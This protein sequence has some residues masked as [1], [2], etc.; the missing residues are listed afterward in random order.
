MKKLLSLI[1]CLALGISLA[2][3]GSS[4]IK[5][6]IENNT[7]NENGEKQY[8]IGICQLVQ[9]AALDAAT[10]GFEDKVIDELGDDVIILNQNASG[11][12]ANCST[13]INSFV[14]KNVDLILANATSPLQAAASATKK[15]PILGTSITDYGSAL[16]LSNFNGI[17]GGNV[18]GTSDLAPLRE[19]AEMIKEWCP[20][21]KTCGI[22]FCSSEANSEY[23]VKEMT[24][25]LKELDI[26][27]KE[28]SFTDSNDVTSITKK[29][30][31][32]S[33]CIYIPTD[34]MAASNA[35]A[36]ANVLIPAKKIAIT[37]EKGP[38]EVCG[39][40]TLSIDYYD[41]GKK[42]GEMAVAILRDGENISDM[43]IEYAPE[44][45]KLYNKKLV[46]Q[47]GLKAFAGYEA[48]E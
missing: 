14:S 8:V 5:N 1:M 36:I 9:H 24:K 12:S 41:L 25:Y 21:A 2:A 27:A 17:V 3:C 48:I 40:A 22:L 13:I 20:E 10:E 11:D 18:S 39:I 7:S 42:T 30:A 16:E 19:Q 44:V 23:Q 15:I 37:G 32:E 4:A 26:E 33:D 47:F 35:E 6:D 34:N 43:K 46:E 45:K 38:C 28:F 31:D 29:A